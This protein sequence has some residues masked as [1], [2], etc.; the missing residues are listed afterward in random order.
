MVKNL[1]AK[2]RDVRDVGSISG[3]GRSPGGGLGN[4]LWY[5]CLG[6]SMDRRA[7]WATVYGGHRVGCDQ[8]NLT[9]AHTHNTVLVSLGC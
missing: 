5:F 7:W 2:V 6:N 8:S 4:P 9:R 3:S 1:P